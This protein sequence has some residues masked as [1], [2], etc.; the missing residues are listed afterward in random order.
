MKRRILTLCFVTCLSVATKAQDGNNKTP[1]L[2]K[3]LSGD[4]ISSVVVNTSGGGIMVTGGGGQSPRI[5]VYINGSNNREQLN[6][7]EI[8]KRLDKSYDMNIAVNGHELSA[9]VKAKHDNI[10][11]KRDGLNI[12]FKIYV[13]ENVSTNLHTSGGGIQLDNLRGKEN[14]TTSGGGLIVNALN[15][16]IHGHTS[17][18]GIQVSNSGDNIDLETSGGGIQAKNCKGTIKLVTSG[19]GIQFKHLD[20]TINAHTSGGGIEGKYISG[21][22]VTNTSGGGISLDNMDCSLDASS[23]AGSVNV[24]MNHVG[25]YLKL[26]TSSGNIA[27]KLPAKQGLDLN[28]NAEKIND[29]IASDFHG[30]WTK[31]NVNG[32]VNGGGAHVDVHANNNIDVTFN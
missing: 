7:E 28:L 9:T 29:E 14:F 25:K 22:L 10:D 23:S 31:T 30:T 18:G 15:G 11:W 24:Q 19:G 1:Y 27:L 4:A 3:S 26:N 2:T 21:E 32:S 17:G 12:S 8:Q 6:K 20:G 16:D 5:E 13:P